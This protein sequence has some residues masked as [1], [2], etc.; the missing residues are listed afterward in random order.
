MVAVLFYSQFRNFASKPAFKFSTLC[1]ITNLKRRYQATKY[2]DSMIL[3]QFC[4]ALRLSHSRSTHV[5]KA[6]MS[7]KHETLQ[8]T[9]IY[10]TRLK[11][12]YRC[13]GFVREDFIYFQNRKMI[14]LR[15]CIKKTLT[16][17][18]TN[19]INDF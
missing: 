15:K 4:S 11:Y 10:S 13:Y 12:E 6:F 17:F 8:Y 3:N 16:M 19:E 5:Y 14:Q 18:Y 9:I 2:V 7:L 1:V